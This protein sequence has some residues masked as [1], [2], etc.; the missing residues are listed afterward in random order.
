MD[1]IKQYVEQNKDK[2]LEELFSLIRIP[3]ISA[4]EAHK[5]DMWRV[6]EFWRDMLLNLG[7]D[8]A[9]IY[10]TE[11][12]PI[13]YA[14]KIID[15]KLPTVL[16][17]GHADVMPVDPIDQW[18]SDPFEPVIKDGK[19]YARGADDDKGQSMIQAKAFET[20]LKLNLLRVNVKFVIEGEEELAS[21][22]LAK[23]MEE[24]KDMLK[25]DI[26]LVSDTSMLAKDIPSITTGIRG[27]SYIEV[28][29]KGPNRDLHSGL[30]GG[31]VANP[32]NILAKM[33]GSLH[34]DKG[35]I[36]IP[37]FYDDV[38]EISQEERRKLNMAPFDEEQYRKSLD[39]EELF[40]EEGYTVIE[41]L[42]IRPT[43]DVNG[44]WGGYTGEGAK[45]VI[46]AKASAKISMRLVPNQD[47]HKISQLFV[48]HFRKIAPKSVKVDVKVLH[49][50]EP[51]VC[52]ID[53]PGYKA[54]EK[55][56]ADVFGK[57]PV[58][59]RSGGSIPIIATFE[60]IIGAKTILMG[61]GLEEDRIHAPNE[62]FPL[63][64]FYK[65]IETVA[66]FYIHFADIMGVK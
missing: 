41:R 56:Y 42:G 38:M 36:T 30:F 26:I 52:P 29:V 21:A 62:N 59:F 35:R 4:E 14:E 15:P 63:E 34:D 10:E 8:K 37:G 53:L 32:A 48:E 39:V 6:Q 25:T 66:R 49:G 46:P 55:A 28:T 61:F 9:V 31:A 45:T 23:W 44:I 40:G 1:L 51:Y 50:G 11:G 43:L 64:L 3:S 13:T 16:V 24:H 19:I 57:E 58:P 22:S 60:K 47:S 54:A 17:Y 7:V 65:G 33:I 2:F 5:K 12:H 18:D 27:L 20:V